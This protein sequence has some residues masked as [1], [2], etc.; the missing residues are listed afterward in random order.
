MRK[1]FPIVALVVAMALLAA[2]SQAVGISGESPG[3][4]TGTGTIK[5][6]LPNSSG[7][8][9]V[10]IG[11]AKTNTNYYELFAY[12]V[13]NIYSISNLSSSGGSVTVAPDS[14]TVIV[15]AGVND[16]SGL[17][18]MLGSGQ[19]TNVVVTANTTTPVTITLTNAT[20]SITA[21]ASVTTNATFNVTVAG[22]SGC[23]DVVVSGATGLY[24]GSTCTPIASYQLNQESWN[25]VNGPI[26]AP[27]SAGS[28]TYQW[29]GAYIGF[30]NLPFKSGSTGS[31]NSA[32][33]TYW[34]TPRAN[35]TLTAI[36]TYCA[37]SVNFLNPPPSQITTTVT[38]GSGQ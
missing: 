15:L 26:T 11:F 22:D 29:D 17:A 6:V 28:A 18:E 14:Y 32:T 33:G 10:D 1:S 2:C 36:N 7:K 37:V 24:Q 34:M 8:G 31:P 27:S 4:G 19:A 38:W 3:T 35:S 30:I 5:V 20:F 16:G 23:A 12:G 21:P 13:N 9:L 25:F